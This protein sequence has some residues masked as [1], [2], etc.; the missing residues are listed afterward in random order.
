MIDIRMHLFD[1]FYP[2]LCDC[3]KVKIPY[4]AWVCDKCRE[5]LAKLELPP[6]AWEQNQH[7]DTPFPWDGFL[8]LYPYRDAAKQGILSLKQGHKGFLNAAADTLAK[9][10]A[11]VY[12][13]KE[14]DCISFVPV[15]KL[16]RSLQGYSHCELLADALSRRLSI[17]VEKHLLTEQNGRI[18]QHQLSAEERK[19]YT[20]RFAHTGKDLA[21]KTILLCDDIVTTGI[22]LAEC[23]KLLKECG[24]KRVYTAVCCASIR[25]EK[26]EPTR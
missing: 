8:A 24:A 13:T 6:R 23:T 14:I 17:P 15:T 9:R 4:G 21:D 12:D 22:T 3:C 16:R 10:V 26:T 20:D 5:E 7:A 25:T 1:F 19:Q 18:R 2:N 11:E